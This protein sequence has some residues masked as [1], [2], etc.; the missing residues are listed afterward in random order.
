MSDENQVRILYMEDDQGLARLFQ[1]RLERVGY[2]VDL[3]RDG[4]EVLRYFL[5]YDAKVKYH[6]WNQRYGMFVLMALIFLHYMTAWEPALVRVDVLGYL[7]TPAWW[8]AE[9]IVGL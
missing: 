4:H 5:P 2:S 8:L 7:L 1:K 9:V 3:A 6:S